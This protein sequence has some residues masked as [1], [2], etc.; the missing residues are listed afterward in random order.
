MK[1]TI[2]KIWEQF[3]EQLT[4]N[5]LNVYLFYIN[6]V[7][8]YFIII[9]YRKSFRY[10]NA[11]TQKLIKFRLYKWILFFHHPYEIVAY[12]QQKLTWIYLSVRD[13]L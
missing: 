8:I 10:K 1:C 2:I 4:F 13:L 5:E 7:F 11:P 3:C 12:S 6:Y 9:L